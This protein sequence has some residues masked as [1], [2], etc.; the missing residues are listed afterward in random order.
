M[1]KRTNKVSY[2]VGFISQMSLH[3][4]N[5]MFSFIATNKITIP[6]EL[7]QAEIDKFRFLYLE[8][9]NY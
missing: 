4:E 8:R 1:Q 3:K 6:Y 7:Q 9:I 2:R 5:Q